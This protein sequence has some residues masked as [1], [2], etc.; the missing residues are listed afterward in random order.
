MKK[1]S[2][3]VLMCCSCCV[4]AWPA[5]GT[6][7]GVKLQ[8]TVTVP[9]SGRD[10]PSIMRASVACYS[11]KDMTPLNCH[12]E[13]ELDGFLDQESAANNGGHVGHSGERPFSYKDEQW[14][15]GGTTVRLGPYHIEGYTRPQ[16]SWVEYKVPSASAKLKADMIVTTPEGWY[17]VKN[18]WSGNT[19]WDE[20]TIDVGVKGLVRLET[21]ESIALARG[22][23][24][25]HPEGQYGRPAAI[26]LLKKVADY[27]KQKT[28]EQLSVND[29]SLPKGGFFDL[30]FNWDDSAK[31]DHEFHRHGVD[32]DINQR[33]AWPCDLD[34]DL[35]EA[36]DEYLDPPPNTNRN[37]PS[38]VLCEA[39][40]NDG[41][42]KCKHIDLD[43]PKQGGT[44]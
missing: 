9:P 42:K 39:C 22:G 15:R 19:I 13:Y 29:L 3:L 30:E 8:K 16:A 20:L 11:L 24:K 26:A 41:D 37:P 10:T 35:F 44:I 31:K 23:K 14:D 38:A 36:A 28:D 27:Y 21:S 5:I 25:T 34:D 2:Y 12:F 18:C 32:A 40:D 43:N 4:L 7:K 33:G 17:C 1:L 6:A